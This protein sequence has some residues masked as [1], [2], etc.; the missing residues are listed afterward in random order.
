MHYVI[1]EY[2]DRLGALS[3]VEL[4]GRCTYLTSALPTSPG[5]VRLEGLLSGALNSKCKFW[6]PS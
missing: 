3:L 2:Q 5:Q 1:E 6:V 4:G